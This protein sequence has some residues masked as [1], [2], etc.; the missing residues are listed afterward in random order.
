MQWKNDY[1]TITIYIVKPNV[2][3]TIARSDLLLEYKKATT[4]QTVIDYLSS[5]WI[6]YKKVKKLVNGY[7][8]WVSMRLIGLIDDKVDRCN[9]QTRF[10]TDEKEKR[11]YMEKGLP[12]WL[13]VSRIDES[14]NYIIVV[15]G[16]FDFLTLVQEETN[17]IG[18]ISKNSKDKLE[19]L[20]TICDEKWIDNL[21]VVTDIGWKEMLYDIETL[22]FNVVHVDLEEFGADD[23][24]NSFYIKNE[25]PVDELVSSIVSIWSELVKDKLAKEETDKKL[26]RQTKIQLWQMVPQ[27]YSSKEY[28]EH[29]H[30]T[31]TEQMWT[32]QRWDFVLLVWWPGTGKTQY[33]IQIV[34]KNI[35]TH[36]IRFFSY[37]DPMN[38]ILTNINIHAV[39]QWVQRAERWELTHE[40]VKRIQLLNKELLE[41]QNFS[42]ENI[43]QPTFDDLQRH[44]Y[45]AQK[46]WVD[47]VIIDN[48]MS[49]AHETFNENQIQKDV[50]HFLA[51][52]CKESWLAV[53]M[54]HHTNKTGETY[55][56][57][58]HTVIRWHKVIIMKR[59][60]SDPALVK[61]SQT[62]DEKET[63][64][65]R[66][67]TRFTMEK[68]KNLWHHGWSKVDMYWCRW[69]YFDNEDEFLS[70]YHEPYRWDN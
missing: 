59:F 39:P 12:S 42:Y 32:I 11:F 54:L 43:E 45:A 50:S 13:Y 68:Q 8:W 10:L 1:R 69:Q 60:S 53:L 58:Q 21:Y 7:R 17:V 48:L 15:E 22:P 65:F 34:Q 55:R 57:S 35:K 41:N 51:D 61:K 67:S 63:V 24:L 25:V 23:D 47:L 52:F 6:D 9:V 49:I 18:M 19:V 66:H 5:R 37:E 29:P 2:M 31:L 26:E 38:M 62:M 28:M 56:W 46:D 33:A 36:K 4:P 40:D 20:K 14:K 3:A 44:V 70:F 64:L 30:P 16:M 27:V